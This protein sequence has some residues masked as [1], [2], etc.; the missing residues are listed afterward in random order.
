MAKHEISV[1]LGLFHAAAFAFHDLILKGPFFVPGDEL[2]KG[3]HFL[4]FRPKPVQNIIY[5]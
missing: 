5:V 4:T 3:C 2:F 1:H